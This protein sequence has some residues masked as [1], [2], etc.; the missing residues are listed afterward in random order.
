MAVVH[1]VPKLDGADPISGRVLGKLCGVDSINEEQGM[2][3]MT[4]TQRLDK[5]WSKVTGRQH[6]FRVVL[7]YKQRGQ[8]H[9][10]EITMY[11]TFRLAWMP[12]SD[13]FYREIRKHYG[14][15]V[16][17]A[18]KVHHGKLNDGHITIEDIAY[19]GRF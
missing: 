18:A 5:L 19:L 15:K 1:G 8:Q 13:A 9:K 10:T 3:P 12:S 16:I 7:G 11:K 2:K 4:I 17:G 6:N 14:P